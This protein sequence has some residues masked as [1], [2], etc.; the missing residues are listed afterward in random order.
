MK[1]IPGVH[2]DRNSLKAQGFVELPEGLAD[3]QDTEQGDH[4]LQILF[5][6][7][8]GNWVQSLGCFLTKSNAKGEILAKVILEGINL[9]E[10]SGLMV[11]GVVVDG[12]S[13]NRVMW[14]KFGV[15][16]ETSSCTHPKDESRRLW[17]FSDWCHLIKCMRNMMCPIVPTKKKLVSLESTPSGTSTAPL[18]DDEDENET[19]VLLDADETETEVPMQKGKKKEKKKRL[20]TD[21][22]FEARRQ[23]A[24]NRAIEVRIKDL[25]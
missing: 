22:E 8:Q 11:D 19:E 12:A 7:F 1:L 15:G 17:F 16:E 5:Q 6:P 13:W 2:F 14:D 24:L 4:A 23:I 21:A 18:P 9:S 10:N 3:G 25:K 20:E